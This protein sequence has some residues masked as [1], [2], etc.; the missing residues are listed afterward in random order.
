MSWISKEERVYNVPTVPGRTGDNNRQIRTPSRW[1][2]D[3]G[4]G[5]DSAQ[6]AICYP[7]DTNCIN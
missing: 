7:I 6:T 5:D 4:A 3:I 2:R 1:A